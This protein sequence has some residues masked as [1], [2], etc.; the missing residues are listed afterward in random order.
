MYMGG[1]YVFSC[2]MSWVVWTKVYRWFDL[3]TV[4]PDSIG[5]LFRCFLVPIRHRMNASKGMLLVWHAVIWVLWK[6]RNE[7]I[8]RGI[9]IGPEEIFD[10]IQVVSWKWL[11]AKKV[12]SPCLFYEGCIEP[13]DCIV[14]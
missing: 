1:L 11:M 3:T 9:V 14:R 12:S 7:R 5:A 4:L 6:A 8:F 10:R 2:Q 13:F